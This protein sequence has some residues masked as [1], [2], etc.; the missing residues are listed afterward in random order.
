MNSL[1]LTFLS[2]ILYA[3]S[4]RPLSWPFLAWVALVPFFL[5]LVKVRPVRAMLY[6]MVWGLIAAYGVGWWFPS[7][8]AAY[9]QV[10]PV[11]GWVGFFAVSIGLAGS[12]LAV[13]AGW[14]SWMAARGKANPLIVAAGWG[15]CEFARANLFVGNPWALSG[16]SQV[17]WPQLMQTA[18]AAGPYGVGMLIAVVN[19][20]LASFF[21]PSLRTQRPVVTFASVLA[22]LG[23]MLLY[24]EWRLSQIF[25]SGTPIPVMLV[26]AAINARD[27]WKPETQAVNLERYLTLT[28][29]AAASHL[30]VIFWPEYAIDF[31]L[32]RPS[33][34]QE[35]V[36]RLTQDLG[37]DLILGGQYYEYGVSDL[38]F[39]NSVFLVRRGKLVGRYDKIYLLP[40]AENNQMKAVFPQFHDRYA[41]GQ[42]IRLLRATAGEVG[43]FVCFES[44]YPDLARRFAVQ[45]AE[46]LANPSNDSWFGYAAPAQLALDIASVRAIENRRYLVR[47]TST[48]ISAVV[49]P[50]GRIIASTAFDVPEVL[51]TTIFRSQSQTPYQRWGDAVAWIVMIFV[52]LQSA[53]FVAVV[54]KE[55]TK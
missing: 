53:Y 52:F 5:V 42:Q 46:I 48:G 26:Q 39:R 21:T 45:G 4:F 28:R 47:A 55:R 38:Q 41:S 31:H 14:L 32:Q 12:Y 27:R 16:Y 30:Q 6:G 29:S 15:V 7:M 24:G 43:V 44:M 23:V 36:F 50:Y 13:F 1:L 22:V 40:F 17:A 10:A 20:Y 25:T 49:D 9:L 11:F 19:A 34:M 8:V 37:A 54:R 3:G 33:V 18:D 51:T 35:A 2:A